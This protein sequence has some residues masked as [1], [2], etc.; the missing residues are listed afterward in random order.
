MFQDGLDKALLVF[1]QGRVN[2][3]GGPVSEPVKIPLITQLLLL[4]Q[5]IDQMFYLFASGSICFCYRFRFLELVLYF[6]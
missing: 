6:F 2:R 4:I 3:R 5:G 1:G